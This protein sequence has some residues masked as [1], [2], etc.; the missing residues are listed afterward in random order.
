MNTNLNLFRSTSTLHSH[1][2]FEPVPLANRVQ[3]IA[4][5]QGLLIGAMLNDASLTR[6]LEMVT[7]PPLNDVTHEDKKHAFFSALNGLMAEEMSESDKRILVNYKFGVQFSQ[8]RPPVLEIMGRFHEGVLLWKQKRRKLEDATNLPG[9]LR[10]LPPAEF[11][12][13]GEGLDTYLAKALK[14]TKAP[15]SVRSVAIGRAI[16]TLGTLDRLERLNFFETLLETVS[17]ADVLPHQR[18]ALL[19]KLAA[20][21]PSLSRKQEREEAASMCMFSVAKILP[22]QAPGGEQLKAR[23]SKLLDLLGKVVDSMPWS[24]L[25]LF[26]RDLI[27]AGYPE[28]AY[29]L[30]FIAASQAG[31]GRFRQRDTKDFLEELAEDRFLHPA[32]DF[33]RLF[34]LLTS[35]QKVKVKSLEFQEWL[36]VEEDCEGLRR[37]KRPADGFFERLGPCQ[38]AQWPNLLLRVAGISNEA[39]RTDCLREI[40]RVANGPRNAKYSR[41]PGHLVVLSL[42]QRFLDGNWVLSEEDLDALSEAAKGATLEVP[43]RCRPSTVVSVGPLPQHTFL[44]HKRGRSDDAGREGGGRAGRSGSGL[45]GGTERFVAR[46]PYV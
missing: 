11:G 32:A 42:A 22:T 24:D 13:K 34:Q 6:V 31:V 29:Q 39:A 7:L 8:L 36:R 30:L 20:R 1:A 3:Q 40:V 21:I 28:L 44:G 46:T 27:E 2:T 15:G 25:C 43:A 37:G 4:L 45:R 23:L 19:A 35:N 38:P 10:S 16:E 33:S 9:Q 14:D 12:K 41:R 18:V 5:N 17:T 26:R